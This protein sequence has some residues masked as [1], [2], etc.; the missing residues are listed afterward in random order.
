MKLGHRNE[1]CLVTIALALS[2]VSAN[3]LSIKR[4]PVTEQVLII[5]TPDPQFQDETEANPTTGATESE[6]R[7]EATTV[8]SVILH[9]STGESWEVDPT[10][11]SILSKDVEIEI[12]TN[13]PV[14]NRLM[15]DQPAESSKPILP[16]IYSFR[17]E[18]DIKYRY[19]R[20]YVTSRVANKDPTKAQ[21]VTF[22]VVLP[23]TAFISKFIMEIDGKP[24]EAYVKEKEEAK[25]DYIQAQSQG[26]SAGLVEKSTR[27]S[28]VFNVNVNVKPQTKVT[29]NLTYE[30][31]LSR[32]LGRYEQAININPDQ[33]SS[34]KDYQIL[35][36]IEE[37]R[38][39]TLV[40]VPSLSNDIDAQEDSE[41]NN[42]DA[43]IERPAPNKAKISWSP[44]T[45]DQKKLVKEGI[46]GKFAVQYD[47][48]RDTDAGQILVM[49]GYFVHFFAPENLPP[50]RK[51]VVFILDISGSMWGRKMEQLK[52]SQKKIL[53]DLSSE[54]FFN[55]ITFSSDVYL[56]SPE[57]S[58]NKNDNND[59]FYSYTAAPVSPQLL[60]KRQ[61][62][63]ATPGN[64]VKAKEFI[65]S[66]VASG[67]T[68][69]HDA[70]IEA[71]NLTAA[72]KNDQEKASNPT[73]EA[74]AIAI[75]TTLPGSPSTTVATST[76][77]AVSSTS[78][79]GSSSSTTS[80]EA[81]P[82]STTDFEE[83]GDDEDRTVSIV[84]IAKSGLSDIMTEIPE[85]TTLSSS[86]RVILPPNVQSLIMFLTD[87]EPT[88]G[89]TDP[90]E[91]QKLI[92]AANRNLSIPIFSLGFGEGADFPFL[93]KLSLQNNGFGRKIYEASDASLQLQGF[94]NEIASPLLSNVK[95]NY[96]SPD[97]NVTDITVTS[98]STIFGGTEIAVAGKLVAPPKPERD[99]VVEST[100]ATETI[101]PSNDAQP[102][103][104]LSV[105][106]ATPGLDT[107]D[108]PNRP[109]EL[110]IACDFKPSENYFFDVTIEGNGR[111]GEVEFQD[112]EVLERRRSCIDIPIPFFPDRIFPPRPTPPPTPEDQ[113]L[114]RLWAY[115]TIQQLI[116]KDLAQLDT[117][118]GDA[119]PSENSIDATP[120]ATPGDSSVETTVLPV[121]P[122]TPAETSVVR[123]VSKTETPKERAL[124]LA[125]KYGFVTPLTSL[126]V[127]KPN[128]SDVTNAVPTDAR[129]D[130]ADSF[131]GKCNQNY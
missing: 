116:E 109:L 17:I 14:K 58:L 4:E 91:I 96:T 22:S 45:A 120:A 12:A 121:G 78:D 13:V 92:Q 128:S 25:K 42:K 7:D 47:I 114:E 93:K 35:V 87:G 123:N 54:D 108:S 73:T 31:L 8:D 75:E 20:T 38:N 89:V 32:R 76:T 55:I 103:T 9:D 43:V 130:A 97:Y 41:G 74:E 85:T 105:E 125:L 6:L 52:E 66:L 50:L 61:P 122:N 19:S 28:N 99:D 115:L 101:A 63:P 33:V 15:A 44:S 3:A 24:Y 80:T 106:D 90:P 100:A 30:E 40:R 67:G 111:D 37:S 36:N 57:D 81:A 64:I 26:Q 110:S 119:D 65:D 117:K 21:E 102:T 11:S 126:V 53:D 107:F 69:I 16:E 129:P 124:R 88:V 94:Y 2:F 70:I 68:N 118:S 62:L 84:D 23:E 48:D 82:S 34:I 127:V 60:A 112:V 131:Y 86:N 72:I 39:L 104:E 49:Q 98:F 95:F 51:H 77:G 83:E 46:S 79:S 113:F 56:W 27:N 18:S 1:W 5:T 10:S 59:R 29:F 71:L